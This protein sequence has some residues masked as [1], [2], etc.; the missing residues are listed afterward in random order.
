MKTKLWLTGT[1]V[2]ALGGIGCSD[3][4]E[5]KEVSEITASRSTEM[6]RAASTS[7]RVMSEMSSL[8]SMGSAAAILQ[9]TFGAVPLMGSPS[10]P[11]TDPKG[12]DSTPIV[13]PVP[14]DP[15]A[16][17]AQAALVEKYLKERIFIEANVEATEGDSTIFRIQG[18]DLCTTGERPAD[19]DCVQAVDKLELRIRATRTDND[20]LDLGFQFGAKRDEPVVLSFGKKTMA[21]AVDLGET[22]DTVQ[23]LIPEAATALPRVMVGRVELRLTENGA[24]D[25]TFST[26]IL[27]AIRIEIDGERGGTHSFSTAKATPLSELRM[28]ANAKRLSFELNLGT[29][30]YKGPYGGTS[31]LSS[32]QLVYSLSGL[33]FEFSAEEGQNDFV[34]AHVGLGEAQSYMSLNGTKIITADLNALSGRHFDLNLSQ[35][36][37]GLP[38]VRVLPE[39]DLAAK[40]FMSP[41]KADPTAEVPSFYED[42]SYRVRLS[43]GGSPSIRPVDA[44]TA[45]GFPGGIQVVSGELSLQGKN[46]SVTVPAGKCLVGKQAAAEGSH[47]LLGHFEARNCQ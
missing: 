42:E 15:T 2:L 3:A 9:K 19:P 46:A 22:K 44:N 37:D 12:C 31:S 43:G 35:G 45:T 21:V 24:Q 4:P 27:D 5:A 23:F 29:T 6:I 17:D 1:M 25:V 39:F 26:G 30:E 41:L 14:I 34:I 18:D 16:A 10:T 7:A 11:C 40:F 28:D 38:L 13:N 36:A 20:G 8:E 32:Q 33:S 47:P